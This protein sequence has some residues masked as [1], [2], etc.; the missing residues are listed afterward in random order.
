[1]KKIVKIIYSKLS[2]IMEVLFPT[3]ITLFNLSLVFLTLK[4]NN[5]ITTIGLLFCT[6]FM[7]RLTYKSYKMYKQEKLNVISSEQNH[8]L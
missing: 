4:Y 5:K 1:M 8:L 3:M 6:L 2:F 7:V